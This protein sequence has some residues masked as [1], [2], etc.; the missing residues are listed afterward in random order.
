MVVRAVFQDLL[1][2]LAC[3]LGWIIAQFRPAI[4]NACAALPLFTTTVA[5]TRSC[6]MGLVVAARSWQQRFISEHVGEYTKRRDGWSELVSRSAA[7]DQA[8]NQKGRFISSRPCRKVSM[9]P[10]WPCACS[11]KLVFD[12]PCETFRTTAQQRSSELSYPRR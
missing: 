8:T 11:R 7:P 10:M 6:H 4:K 9:A 1:A 2:W 5:K 12:H 3:A